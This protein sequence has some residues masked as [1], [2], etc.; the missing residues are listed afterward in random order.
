MA[1]CKK[2]RDFDKLAL[3]KFKK[4]TNNGDG[5]NLKKKNSIFAN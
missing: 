2:L 4:K 1:L 5:V 3:V